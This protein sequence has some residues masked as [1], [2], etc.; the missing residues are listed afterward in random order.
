MGPSPASLPREWSDVA[1]QPLVCSLRSGKGRWL[2][3]QDGTSH[4]ALSSSLGDKEKVISLRGAAVSDR[5]QVLAWC[6]LSYVGVV[7]QAASSV[8]DRLALCTLLLRSVP[9]HCPTLPGYLMSWQTWNP[10]S[11]RP[12]TVPLDALH[13]GMGALSPHAW[14]LP[15]SPGSGSPA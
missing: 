12:S 3:C 2:G 15:L 13:W 5:V 8:M 9:H 14:Y 1:M 6:S 7:L 4:P 10:C 11:Q